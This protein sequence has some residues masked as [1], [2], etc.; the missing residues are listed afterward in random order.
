ML[1]HVKR[2]ANISQNREKS[3]CLRVGSTFFTCGWQTC[4]WMRRTYKHTHHFNLGLLVFKVSTCIVRKSSERKRQG[5]TEADRQA[6]RQ[7]VSLATWAGQMK[8]G[9]PDVCSIIHITW[10]ESFTKRNTTASEEQSVCMC[11]S[12]C[13]V[14]WSKEWKNQICFSPFDGIY[15]CSC[16]CLCLISSVWPGLISMYGGIGLSSA[17][18]YSLV[19]FETS[20]IGQVRL[21]Q[22]TSQSYFLVCGT[23]LP[24][25]F[26][27][28]LFLYRIA[29]RAKGQWK[30]TYPGQVV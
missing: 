8:R 21:S 23:F 11:V 2:G 27:H 16:A 6:A 19:V 28:F 20:F 5:Q 10:D 24:R 17:C 7:Q 4:L 3:L 15:V 26:T 29:V 14:P 25:H 22:T 9:A 13:S 18:V 30:S 1:E 12:A